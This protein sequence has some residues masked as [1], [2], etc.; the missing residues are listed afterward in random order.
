MGRLGDRH[1]RL[2][3]ALVPQD[4]QN[5]IHKLMNEFIQLPGGETFPR[6]LIHERAKKTLISIRVQE[7]D[8]RGN[9]IKESGTETDRLSSP[10]DAMGYAA[11]PVFRREYEKGVNVDFLS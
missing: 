1:V 11:W 9:P 8:D 4:R 2:T 6:F 7:S 5:V 3:F 10:T